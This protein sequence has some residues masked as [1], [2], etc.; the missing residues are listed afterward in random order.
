MR[1]LLAVKLF[2]GSLGSAAAVS[3]AQ[4]ALFGSRSAVSGVSGMLVSSFLEAGLVEESVKLA[5]LCAALNVCAG[6][7]GSGAR[8]IDRSGS[9][10]AACESPVFAAAVLL[11]LFFAGFETIV[12][13]FSSPLSSIPVR[14]FT[15]YPVHAS[16]SVLAAVAL[17][18]LAPL[19]A[20]LAGASAAVLLHGFFDF[21]LEISGAALI[22]AFG[23][24]LAALI[25]AF[26]AAAFFRQQDPEE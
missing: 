2:L 19:S 10:A 6:T 1:P 23:S 3:L 14:F 13:S 18:R 25:A 7:F 12:Y 22:L 21:C 9:S 15:A 16:A 17:V 24:E 5:F 8:G 4:A 20:R 11:A 26:A